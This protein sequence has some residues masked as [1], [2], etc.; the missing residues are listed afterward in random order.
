[1][2]SLGPLDFVFIKTLNVSGL[3][4]PLLNGLCKS[5]RFKPGQLLALRK[6][7]CRMFSGKGV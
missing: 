5:P 6:Y 2:V 1:M 4:Q 7:S 3:P